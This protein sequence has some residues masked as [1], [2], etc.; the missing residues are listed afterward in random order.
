LPSPGCFTLWTTGSQMAVG[1]SA[2][3]GSRPLLPRKIPDTHFCLRLSKP[4][5]IVWPEGSGKLKINLIG[6]RTCGLQDGSR[7]PQPTTLPRGVLRNV[8]GRL[9]GAM[10]Y[11]TKIFKRNE[12]ILAERTAICSELQ[13][14]AEAQMSGEATRMRKQLGVH[15]SSVDTFTSSVLKWISNSGARRQETRG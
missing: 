14:P 15:A 7:V 9:C 3:R 4:Q 8:G 11:E 10:R 13:S 5:G 1:L 12:G 6:N 2:L